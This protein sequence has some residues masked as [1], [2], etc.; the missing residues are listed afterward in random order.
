MHTFFAFLLI[1]LV[2]SAIYAISASGLVLT[3]VTSGIFNFAHGAVGMF[4]AFLYWEL[5]I[6]LGLPVW[7][8]LFLALFVAAPLI[9]MFL[10]TTVM[11]RLSGATLATKLVITVALLVSFQGLAQGIWGV[12]IRTLPRLWGAH[13]FKVSGLVISWDQVTI[14]LAAVGVAAGLWALLKLTR[15]GVAMRAVV[16]NPELCRVKG[17]NPGLVTKASW[18]LG[19][20]LAGLAAI[21]IAPGLNLDPNVLSLLVVSAYAAAIWGRLQSLPATF[22]GALILGIGSDL[23]IGYLAGSG[24]LANQLEPALPFVLLFVALLVRR[25]ARLAE[26]AKV[27]PEPR[28]PRPIPVVGLSGVALACAAAATLFIPGYQL[29]IGSKGLAYAVALMSLLLL[30]GVSGQVSLMQFS[31]AGVGAVVFSML[32]TGLPFVLG[33]LVSAGAAAALGMLVALPAA[34]LR[35][36]YLALATLAFAIL[37]DSLFFGDDHVLGGGK[38]LAI[39]RP[40]LFGIDFASEKNM[41][42]LAAV[43]ALVVAN[44]VLA[45]RRGAFG[46]K[47]AALRD[48]PTASETQGMNLMKVRL[49]VLGISAAL[50]GVA[51]VLLGSVQTKVGAQNFVYENSLLLLLVAAAFGITRVSGAFGGAMFFVVLPTTVSQWIYDLMRT[52]LPG[53]FGVSAGGTGAAWIQ[54]LSIGLIAFAMARHPE[55]VVGQ[56][57]GQAR[58]GWLSLRRGRQGVPAGLSRRRDEAGPLPRLEPEGSVL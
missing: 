49:Q 5:R 22:A 9:G 25:P 31:F 1:G 18:S 32:P 39:R 28:P 12:Q 58:S 8:A 53:S 35:G 4:L 48:S 45:L 37:L 16:D 21:L 13:Y 38:T 29:L 20:M 40:S 26:K 14:V 57:V 44:I 27:P 52:V 54:P 41:F 24:T 17:I 11:R 56:V 2:D 7:L 33:M 10:E 19:S 34:R 3:Y 43:V 23:A 51:G 42:I 50:A 55:G 6:S 15:L 46:R 30:T 47:L 36:I